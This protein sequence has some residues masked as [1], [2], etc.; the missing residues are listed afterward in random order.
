MARQ[1]GFRTLGTDQDIF[2]Y[3]ETTA[4]DSLA[5]GAD[6]GTG[7]FNINTLPTS[8]AL[9]DEATS[10]FAIDPSADGDIAF[11]PNG[12][13][14]SVFAGGDVVVT[15]GDFNIQGGNFL[16]ASTSGTDG[17]L[18]IGNSA[19]N[20]AWASLTSSTITITEGPNSL[21][22]EVAGMVAS[23][24]Q[25]DAGT[26]TPLLN[27]LRVLGGDNINTAGAGNV[28]TVN[29]NDFIT[30]PATTAVSGIIYIDGD[31]FLHSF[32]TGNVFL[33]TDSGNLTT[34]ST[35]AQNV[36]VGTNS[37]TLLDGGGGGATDNVLIGFNAGAA[38][39]TTINNTALGSGALETANTNSNTAIGFNALNLATGSANTGL[40]SSAGSSITTGES[41]LLIGISAGSNYTTEDS[42]IA[43][44]NSGTASDANTLR[45]GT[46]GSGVRQIDTTFIAG[47]QPTTLTGTTSKPVVIETTGQLGV[48]GNLN[49]PD[50]TTALTDGVITFGTTRHIHN[51]GV[52]N[53]FLGENAGNG[54]LTT[55]SAQ[56]NFALG[57]NALDAL[58]TG[59]G[60][61]AIGFQAGTAITTSIRNDLM[62]FQAGTAITTGNGENVCIGFQCGDQITTGEHNTFIGSNSGGSATAASSSNIYLKNVGAAESNTIRIGTQGNSAGQQDTT[63]IAGI[64]GVTP[65]GG[66]DGMV[67]IDTNGQ[68]GSQTDL[69]MP[70]NPA[71][72]A[73]NSVSDANQTG[74]GNNALVEFDTEVFDQDSNYDIT[75]DTFTA[76]VTGKYLLNAHVLI[77][78]ITAAMNVGQTRIVTSNTTYYFNQQNWGANFEAAADDLGSCMTVIA[79]MD[80]NDT[81]TV[82]VALNGGAGDTAGFVGTGSAIFTRFCGALIS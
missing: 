33:G 56:G 69:L 81:A 29:L 49:I 47:I 21:D 23:E 13:G 42:N 62:G 74:A 9:P 27:V 36:C 40:G 68:L 77:E 45:I 76:P 38:I 30:W 55:G 64:Q 48:A 7:T 19:G 10:N 37:G 78:D 43:I 20:A 5:I 12:A 54:T 63:F 52:S 58:T 35:S 53:F 59:A 22:L 75:T 71:F 32:G 72:L 61:N 3:I 14:E 73:Y 24:Y 66:N 82:R 11:L 18:V 51:F 34:A 79:D 1:T 80:A 46:Q 50:T 25:T 8:G 31:R 15:S 16:L 17:Q 60:N 70:N 67:I 28:L 26:A 44:S 39:T 6:V 65:S 2:I 57:S 4:G 41:N